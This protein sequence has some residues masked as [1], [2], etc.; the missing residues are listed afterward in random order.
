M[1]LTFAKK[2]LAGVLGV[3]VTQCAISALLSFVVSLPLMGVLFGLF[4]I[5][6]ALV[7]RSFWRSETLTGSSQLAR[8]GF[9]L[10]P[11]WIVFAIW[12]VSLGSEA[13]TRM[14][15]WGFIT[16]AVLGLGLFAEHGTLKR[17]ALTI[18]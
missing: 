13:E 15:A 1:N 17:R 11:I 7:L 12:G 16:L 8:A 14:Q 5:L 18:P 6:Q 2:L 3:S 9:L 4:A 10:L